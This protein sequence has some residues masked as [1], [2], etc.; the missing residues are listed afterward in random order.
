MATKSKRGNANGM[1]TRMLVERDRRWCKDHTNVLR[2]L[3]NKE[4]RLS[5]P[6]VAV[7][8]QQ[9][10]QQQQQGDGQGP[11]G[12][13]PQTQY[14]HP[15]LCLPI[16]RPSSTSTISS[17]SPSPCPYPCPSMDQTTGSRRHFPITFASRSAASSVESNEDEDES[18]EVKMLKSK[19]RE[20]LRLL[21]SGNALCS[22]RVSS[23]RARPRRVPRPACRSSLP[24]VS[25]SSTPTHF[26]P[27]CPSSLPPLS[28]AFT[29]GS[30]SPSQSSRTWMASQL[31][32]RPWEKRRRL[33][34]N[35]EVR[36][37]GHILDV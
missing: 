14:L 2:R 31:T 1:R 35:T 17:S 10:Q 8:V 33:P 6:R 34:S 13:S 30:W 37:C 26:F 4:T 24:S 27:R 23:A 29:G 25:S 20:L 28:K 32:S 19:R 12:R 9:Q 36:K 7:A 15:N 22:A 18:E 11:Q 3:A 16:P 5:P 21:C